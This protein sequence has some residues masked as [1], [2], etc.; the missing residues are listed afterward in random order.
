MQVRVVDKVM[1]FIYSETSVFCYFLSCSCWWIASLP[2]VHEPTRK[3]RIQGYFLSTDFTHSK[4]KGNHHTFLPH[5]SG[6][7]LYPGLTQQISDLPLLASCWGH[8]IM[9]YRSVSSS[10]QQDTVLGSSHPSICS[11]S[12]IQATCSWS[13]DTLSFLLYMVKLGFPARPL[14]T[15][16]AVVLNFL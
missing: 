5:S 15:S 1:I 3:L 4:I 2:I 8:S 13:D 12:Q 7:M 11:S 14:P 10:A 16:I 9:K 6:N